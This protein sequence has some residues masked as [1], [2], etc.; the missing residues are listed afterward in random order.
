MIRLMTAVVSPEAFDT[1]GWR[2]PF[3]LSFVLVLI[4]L[5]VRLRVL[6]SP[7]FREVKKA[8]A[9]VKRPFIEVLKEHPMEIL[10]SAFV[11]MSEQ[12]PF[13]IFITFVLTYGTTILKIDRSEL[14]NYTLVAAAVGFVSV[15]LFGYLSDRIGRRLMYGIGIVCTALFAFPYFGLLNTKVAGFVLARDRRVAGVPRHAVR[16]P[17]GA[18]RRELRHQ[19]AVQ[20]CGY[21]LPARLGHRRWAR[22]A[23]R[24]GHPREHRVERRDQ[25]VHHRVLCAVH[26]R[27]LLMPRTQLRRDA[28]ARQDAGRAG[29]RDRPAHLTRAH[30]DYVV[31][32][33]TRWSDNDM[34]GH[35]NNAVYYE[36]FDSAINGWLI[37]GAGADVLALPELGRRRRVR[38]RFF[39]ELEYPR[40]LDVGVRVERLGRSSITYAL[41]P[42]RRGDGGA[43]RAGPL[44][45]RLHRPHLPLSGSDPRCGARAPRPR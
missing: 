19:P 42:V 28:A 24:G 12:A 29:R 16:A 40:R 44:G 15:P 1:W 2:V 26:G 25:L 41:G 37:T 8:D 34:Y 31:S 45:P 10:T 13:Y 23:H 5:Y 30:F 27:P 18:H 35:L 33:T 9:V 21:R 6:E 43:R 3:L 22:A 36:L 4:G 14:L 32:A 7:E 17:G 20:R 38:C 39:R 11:R